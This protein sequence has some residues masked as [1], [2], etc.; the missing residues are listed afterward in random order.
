MVI[1]ISRD[2]MF[3][4]LMR[5]SLL[6]SQVVSLQLSKCSMIPPNMVGYL[7]AAF[8][9]L[10]DGDY[11]ISPT[12]MKNCLISTI[13]GRGKYISYK[14]I[15]DSNFYITFK[16]GKIIGLAEPASLANVSCRVTSQDAVVSENTFT[17]AAPDDNEL[18]P[19][20]KDILL[21]TPKT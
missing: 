20:L 11:I 2:I 17:N 12:I 21:K 13:Y 15:N 7:S 6:R 19:Y 9:T 14:V 5:K 16:K 4:F 3:F 18:P 10:F 1:D 8:E